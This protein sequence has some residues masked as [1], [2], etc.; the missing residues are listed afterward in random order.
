MGSPS[1]GP[2][3]RCSPGRGTLDSLASEAS[4]RNLEVYLLLG[5][6]ILFCGL[7]TVNALSMA[8][9]QRGPEFALLKMLGASRRRGDPHG[10]GPRR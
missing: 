4:D 3:C 5:I 6:I 10:A 7:A 8:I 9:S 1:P 2:R